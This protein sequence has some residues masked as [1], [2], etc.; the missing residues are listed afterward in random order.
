MEADPTKPKSNLRYYN[1][2]TIEIPQFSVI[3]TEELAKN[4]KVQYVNGCL[5]YRTFEEIYNNA[6]EMCRQDYVNAVYQRRKGLF[7]FSIELC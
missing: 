7:I 3:S 2:K 4:I 1:K 5:S 6:S